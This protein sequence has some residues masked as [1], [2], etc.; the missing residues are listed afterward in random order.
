MDGYTDLELRKKISIRHIDLGDVSINFVFE[1]MRVINLIRKSKMRKGLIF[2]R[3]ITSLAPAETMK[4]Q[5]EQQAKIQT[6][7]LP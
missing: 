5:R 1:A 6:R 2:K 7:I 4:E 3:Q